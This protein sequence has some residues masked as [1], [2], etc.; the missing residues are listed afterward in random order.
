MVRTAEAF[1][2]QV[3]GMTPEGVLGVPFFHGFLTAPDRI[4]HWVHCAD[5]P[6][7]H[8]AGVAARITA[9][10]ASLGDHGA[11]APDTVIGV[12]HPPVLRAVAVTFPGEAP[13]EPPYLNGYAVDV[14]GD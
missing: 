13:G 11:A 4:E 12:T 9:F 10:A 1:A 6:G 14:L 8:A 2:D 3:A 7:D 5:P